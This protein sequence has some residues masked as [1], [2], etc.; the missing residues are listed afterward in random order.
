[1]T[2]DS[3]PRSF[4]AVQQ[5]TPGDPRWLAFASAHADATPFHHPAWAAAIADTYGYRSSLLAQTEGDRVLAALPVLDV[6]SRLTGNRTVS[7]PFTD[8]CA[9]LAVSTEQEH[10]LA[11]ALVD[12]QR[13]KEPIEVRGP[14]PERDGIHLG[15]DAVY[16]RLELGDDAAAL[17]RSL[18]SSVRRAIG[19]AERQGIAVRTGTGLDDVRAYYRLHC[20]TRHRQGVPVQSWGFFRNVWSRMI[21]P[22]LGMVALAELD[23]RPIAG[24]VFLAWRRLMVYKYGASDPAHWALRPNNLVM[25]KGIEWGIERGCAELDFGR[26]D[27]DHEGLR[28]FKSSWG[29]AE[30]PLVT[31]RV[32]PRVRPPRSGRSGRAS[33]VLGAVIRRGPEPLGR[34]LGAALYRHVG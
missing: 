15:Q 33:A 21:E 30:L 5:W 1:M 24:A 25:W 12:W 11:E 20:M 10:E 4:R 14:L 3:P 32:A 29:A 17:R 28:R 16:H 26:S 2:V 19:K 9:P 27:L 7:L 34:L 6:R 18:P 13:G 31:A 22:G 23:G 8:R